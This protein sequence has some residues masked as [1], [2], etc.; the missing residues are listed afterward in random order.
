MILYGHCLVTRDARGQWALPKQ[1]AA[2]L[3]EGGVVTIGLDDCLWL[4]P[5]AAWQTWLERMAPQLRLTDAAARKFSRRLFGHAHALTLSH[6]RL[7]LPPALL[8]LAGIQETMIVAGLID[9]FELWA[10]ERWKGESRRWKGE[11]G[12]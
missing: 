1:F 5:M 4:Y 7:R 10:P 11:S 2:A 12:R 6:S 3:A 8:E 9:H